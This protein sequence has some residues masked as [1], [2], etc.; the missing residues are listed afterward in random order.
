MIQVEGL[1][2]KLK[3]EYKNLILYA[4]GQTCRIGALLASCD[5][6]DK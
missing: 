1:C 2:Y 3:H 5:S 6:K 4:S